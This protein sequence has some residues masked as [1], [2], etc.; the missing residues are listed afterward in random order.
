V[1]IAWFSPLP[2]IRSGIASYTAELVPLLRPELDIDCFVERP[3][4]SST[5]AD[6]LIAPHLV[7][8]AHDFVWM[9]Q[10]RPYDLVVYQLGNARYHE[11]MWAYL[12]RYPGVVV[13]HDAMLHHARARHLL[14][15]RRIDD[16][17][18]EF[19]YDH[20]AA[21]VDVTE[22]AVEG[23]SG[24]IYYFWPM[25][26]AVVRTARTI[27]VHNQR[28]A[29]QLR[30]EHPGVPIEA[31]RMGVPAMA[32]EP[33]ARRTI[34]RTLEIADDA[35]V[36]A[37]FGRLTREK[38]IDSILRAMTALVAD[39]INAHLLIGGDG[40]GFPELDA[41][42]AGL[43][44]SGRVHVCGYVADDRVA[45][46][47]AAADAC[48]C[49]RW[50]TAQETSAAWL[51][52]LAAARPTVVTALAHTVDVPTADGQSGRRS[53]PWIDPVAIAVD[54]LNE[55]ESLV[56]AMRRLAS[57]G[58]LRSELAR[59]GHAYWERE[60]RLELMA[61]DYR[62]VLQQAIGRPAPIVDDLPRHLTDD[63]TGL[64]RSLAGSFGLRID[65]LDQPQG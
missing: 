46:F 62:R 36:F 19:R 44:L 30:L 29:E 21:P 50:P 56:A 34:R 12:A 35:V 27:V 49:L 28:V 64:L 42:I 47:L 58:P 37:V 23:L 63:H 32:A 39:G 2:P 51:R 9:H 65:L 6:H 60:H 10:R 13:L 3:E 45:A 15:A 24:S 53:H 38:R 16:Y 18:Q 7:H 1:R 43:G 57:D 52:A 25:V 22:Y 59:A 54:L 11:F 8:D 26:R 17:R 14:S 48:L 4:A 40:S 31:I 20:P 41:R 55:D 33:E 61:D 5:I